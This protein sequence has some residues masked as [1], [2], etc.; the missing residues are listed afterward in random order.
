MRL[1]VVLLLMLA[2]TAQAREVWYEGGFVLETASWAPVE[3]ANWTGL[4]AGLT[5]PP[6]GYMVLEGPGAL[7]IFLPC[8]GWVKD[9][10]IIVI[11][12]C[13]PDPQTGCDTAAAATVIT[14]EDEC[15]K[16]GSRVLLIIRIPK[17]FPTADCR[18][19]KAR[20]VAGQE[21]HYV[22]D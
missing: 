2:A 21:S 14:E 12:G 4:Q 11:K 18:P 1:L 16:Q 6:N 17:I 9:L 10:G 7:E 15:V 19:T 22:Q 8:K 13:V 20:W 3:V 5:I